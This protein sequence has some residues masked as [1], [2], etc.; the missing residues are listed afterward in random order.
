MIYKYCLYI[1]LLSIALVT[2]A[3]ECNLKK[4]QSNFTCDLD[5]L[6]LSLTAINLTKSE[7]KNYYENKKLPEGKKLSELKEDLKLLASLVNKYNQC[8]EGFKDDHIC[9]KDGYNQLK[10]L[11]QYYTGLPISTNDEILVYNKQVQKYKDLAATYRTCPQA[12]NCKLSLQMHVVKD[13]YTVTNLAHK[14]VISYS[15]N[16]CLVS[17]PDK[18]FLFMKS[19]K[20]GG[21]IYSKLRGMIGFNTYLTCSVSNKPF[22]TNRRINITPKS[23][24]KRGKSYLTV[25]DDWDELGDARGSTI[26]KSPTGQQLRF[27]DDAVFLTDSVGV[28]ISWGTGSKKAFIILSHKNGEILETNIF[29][30]SFYSKNSCSTKVKDKRLYPNIKNKLNMKSYDIKG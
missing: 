21:Q 23:R 30:K 14:N 4:V 24:S 2:Q 28:Q 12:E 10:S 6:K 22:K 29:D 27:K 18:K 7:L 5:Y 26:D 16:K 8:I 9:G 19:L 20:T 13:E 3:A 1:L 11:R 17:I 25:V 15:S